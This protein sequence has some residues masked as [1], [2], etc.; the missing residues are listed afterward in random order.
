MNRWSAHLLNAFLIV[1]MV[2]GA[3]TSC[4]AQGYTVQ[5]D[6]VVID[7]EEH[8][9]HW[10]FPIDIVDITPEGTIGPRYIR[11]EVNAVLSATEFVYDKTKRGGIREVG[12]NAGDAANIMDGDLS[13]FWEPDADDPLDRWYVQIDLGRVVSAERIVLRFVEEGEG[14]PFYQFKVLTST[15]QEFFLGSGELMDFRVVGKTK[16]PNR[17]QRVFEVELSSDVSYAPGWTGAVVQYV[18]IVVTDS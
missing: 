7:T 10:S 9:R 6:K 4:W 2:L 12:S 13:T 15:G 1:L 5:T 18:Q 3:F 14:D 11:K 8:W 17:D 16:K